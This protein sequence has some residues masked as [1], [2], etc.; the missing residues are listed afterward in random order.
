MNRTIVY[1]G[2]LPQDTDILQPQRWAMEALGYLLQMTM[3]TATNVVGLACTPTLSASMAVN[4]GPGAIATMTVID[5]TAFGSLPANSAPLM[6]LG[7]NTGTTNF[8]L[9]APSTSGDSVNY[10]IEAAFNETD[11]GALVLPYYNSANPADP[12]SGPNNDGAAQN[13][14]RMETVALVLKAGAAA[15]TGTQTTPAV[16]SGY[17][18]LYII[19]V[20]A[21][22]TSVTASDISVYPGAPFAAGPVQSVVGATGNVT[23]AQIETAIGLS[24][25]APLASPALTGTPT[26]P[27]AASGTA[28]SQIATTNFVATNYAPLDSPIF[29]N[30][31][32]APT[33][34]PGT[35]TTQLATT[36]FVQGQ[37]FITASTAPVTSVVG[38]TGAVTASQIA[39]ALSGN[40]AALNGSNSE[41]FNAAAATSSNEVVNLGQFSRYASS[42]GP[43]IL[44]LPDGTIFQFGTG[45]VTAT[46]TGNFASTVTLPEAFPNAGV[47]AI[48]NWGGSNPPG[49]GSAFPF[50]TLSNTQVTLGIYAPGSGTYTV[51]YMAVGY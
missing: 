47:F 43:V 45:T 17:V 19:T 32:Y 14:A 25:Y 6:K 13:T 34:A 24:N 2:A 39:S 46:G 31:A 27:T 40:F 44:E 3:G 15:A 4:V 21:G 50:T 49:G 7:I 10:L 51:A 48:G 9:T 11:S 23:A 42:G 35:N 8:T 29:I 12:Y 16:D 20:A 28:S 26:A 5:T 36:A 41:Q 37:G 33:A 30:A 22:Q 18:G 38:D 1:P